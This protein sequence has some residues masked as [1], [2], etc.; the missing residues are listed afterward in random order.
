MRSDNY[1]PFYFVL[2]GHLKTFK[3]MAL[4]FICLMLLVDFMGRSFF[5]DQLA[6]VIIIFLVLVSF[7]RFKILN[8]VLSLFLGLVIGLEITYM[9]ITGERISV[10]ILNSGTD[11]QFWSTLA[12][13]KPF[14][15]KAMPLIFFLSFL[16]I[17]TMLEIK[18]FKW[19]NYLVILVGC[20]LLS[21]SYL[22]NN[23][24][25]L[26]KY[27]NNL[28]DVF[29]ESFDLPSMDG[30]K[31]V[32]EH[33]YMFHKYYPLFFGDM[34]YLVMS[35]YELSTIKDNSFH[36]KWPHGIA[37]REDVKQPEK[38]IV[39]LGESS[40][41]THYSLYGYPYIT[42]PHLD[43]FYQNKT[44]KYYSD[45]ISPA[46]VTRDSLK[47]SLSYATPFSDEFFF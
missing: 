29:I 24:V 28:S 21:V 33:K 36:D 14:I 7:A 5:I 37:L 12:V 34:F 23:M 18:L 9:I 11:N 8:I 1:T 32:Y 19:R 27:N 26:D 20:L 47:L 42:T 45:V 30:P 41:S 46:T 15:I 43:D 39:V 4:C 38:V 40:V 6:N 25:L 10:T 13:S 2:W 17:K 22:Y 3:W 31:L 35:S 16:F 44:I